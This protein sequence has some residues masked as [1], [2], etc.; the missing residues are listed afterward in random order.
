MAVGYIRVSTDMQVELGYSL[1]NQ[2][3][4]KQPFPRIL[5]SLHSPLIIPSKESKPSKLGHTGAIFGLDLI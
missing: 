3:Y 4:R 1:E 2:E 5:R